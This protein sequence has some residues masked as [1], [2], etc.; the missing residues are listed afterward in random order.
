MTACASGCRIAK[1][2]ANSAATSTKARI[3]DGGCRAD[4]GAIMV[5]LAILAKDDFH[6]D[7][8]VV[9]WDTMDGPMPGRRDQSDDDL[10]V[11]DKQGPNSIVELT[12]TCLPR[13]ALAGGRKAGP[14]RIN[15]INAIIES[16]EV[17][18][19][20][21]DSGIIVPLAG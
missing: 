19:A 14:R 7:A 5:A 11:D 21:P 1:V 6:T 17:N 18:V 16:N 3:W 12:M 4:I 9:G 10:E 13:A 20:A 8:A 15:E 2:S